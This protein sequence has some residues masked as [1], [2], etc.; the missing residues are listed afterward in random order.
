M[1]AEDARNEG[2]KERNFVDELKQLIEPGLL[3]GRGGRNILVLDGK[4]DLRKYLVENALNSLRSYDFNEI[5]INLS[6]LEDKNDLY[7][8]ILDWMFGEK[9]SISQMDAYHEVKRFF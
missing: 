4:A 2:Y 6:Q 3:N 5:H 1:D 9:V 8:K 7:L